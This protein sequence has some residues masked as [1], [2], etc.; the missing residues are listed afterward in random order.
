MDEEIGGAARQVRAPP[1]HLLWTRL[2]VLLGFR[3]ILVVA[4]SRKRRVAVRVAF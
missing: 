2:G 3:S 1:T 4:R